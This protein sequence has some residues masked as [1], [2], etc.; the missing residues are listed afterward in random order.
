MREF[1][2]KWTRQSILLT[3]VTLSGGSLLATT[4]IPTTY[5]FPIS[6]V[7]TNRLWRLRQAT[8]TPRRQLRPG[9]PRTRNKGKWK[10]RGA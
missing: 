2:T 9:H 1:K 6:A 4:T 5:M 10:K 3:A 8:T 7:D